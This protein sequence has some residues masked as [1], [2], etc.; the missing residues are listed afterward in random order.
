M[1][2]VVNDID[3]I[4]FPDMGE[5]AFDAAET[6][7]PSADFFSVQAKLSRDCNRGQNILRVMLPG[8]RQK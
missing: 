5:T 3:V 2:V 6:C 8:H 7:Q 4:P 1:P